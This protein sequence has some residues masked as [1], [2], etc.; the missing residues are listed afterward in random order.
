MKFGQIM[1]IVDELNRKRISETVSNYYRNIPK[2]TELACFFRD[3]NAVS[4]GIR[5]S[6]F[7]RVYFMGVKEAVSDLLCEFPKGSVMD[8]VSREH[9]DYEWLRK[10]GFARK[11][12]LLRYT[13]T[14]M[15]IVF[16]E[17]Q[18]LRREVVSEELYYLASSEDLEKILK[19]IYRH[20]DVVSSHYPSSADVMRL[21]EQ[22]LVWIV[23]EKGKIT[24]LALCALEGKKFYLNYLLNLSEKV[25]GRN[26]LARAMCEV[27]DRGCKYGYMWVSKDNTRAIHVYESLLYNPDGVKNTIF[28]KKN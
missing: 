7:L 4:F 11:E 17:E 25:R 14:D 18:M 12:E 6:G 9:V 20:F 13:N 8:C 22:G 16:M 5:E 3:K 19:L 23:K 15:T 1:P 2:N 27:I 10:S 24:S 21:I 28:V 26:L